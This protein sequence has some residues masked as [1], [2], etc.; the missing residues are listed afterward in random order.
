[1]S[2]QFTEA[3]DKINQIL[4]STHDDEFTNKEY[5]AFKTIR[6]AIQE[7]MP[8]EYQK[9]VLA[10]LAELQRCA[11]RTPDLVDDERYNDPIWLAWCKL[12]ETLSGDAWSSSS[13]IC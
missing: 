7:A 11:E 9:S 4:S 12:G 1:M 5:I 8:T 13:A 2:K 3:A 6:M 10:S